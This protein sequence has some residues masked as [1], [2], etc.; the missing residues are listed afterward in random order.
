MR[1]KNLTHAEETWFQMDSDGSEFAYWGDW[2]IVVR[3]EPEY[4]DFQWTVERPQRLVT[5]RE[6]RVAAQGMASQQTDARWAG[7]RAAARLEAALDA[8]HWAEFAAWSRIDDDRLGGWW[9]DDDHKL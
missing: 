2:A 6:G 9:K 7:M 4:L 5:L 8:D 1:D 3:V